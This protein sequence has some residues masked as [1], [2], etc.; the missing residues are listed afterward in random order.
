MTHLMEALEE[1][2][3]VQHVYANFDFDEPETQGAVGADCNSREPGRDSRPLTVQ[4]PLCCAALLRERS[5]KEWH[6]YAVRLRLFS[7]ERTEWQERPTLDAR[8]RC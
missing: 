3:D 7:N 1:P 2:D 6:G 4:W 8:D 5:G